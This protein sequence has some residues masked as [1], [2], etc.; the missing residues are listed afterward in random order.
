MGLMGLWI[1]GM[2]I[3]EKI[4]VSES[5]GTHKIPFVLKPHEFHQT[6]LDFIRFYS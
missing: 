5:H 2:M 3:F 1:L 4:L 6:P